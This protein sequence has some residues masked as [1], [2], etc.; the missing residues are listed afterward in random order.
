[1]IAAAENAR[2][3]LKVTLPYLKLSEQYLVII[4]YLTLGQIQSPIGRLNIRNTCFPL[5]KTEVTRKQLWPVA[6]L[7]SLK[8]TP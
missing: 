8:S 4:Y 3:A 5:E 2:T 7:W 6:P 1:M